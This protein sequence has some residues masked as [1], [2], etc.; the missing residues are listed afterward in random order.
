MTVKQVAEYFQV[1]TEVIKKVYQNNKDEIESDG[2]IIKSLLISKEI[3]LRNGR[4]T[5]SRP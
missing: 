3:R 2:T 5:N 4:E 1:D